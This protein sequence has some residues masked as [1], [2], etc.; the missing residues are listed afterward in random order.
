MTHDNH[1]F[2]NLADRPGHLIR[3]LHQIHVAMFLEECSDFNLTP[4]QFGVL[5]VLS[6]GT[7]R[8]QVTIARRIGVD[9]NTAAD[10]IKRLE[11]RGL[12]E[13]PGD[14]A[15][16]RTKLARITAAGEELVRNVQPGMMRA[17]SRLISPLGE[18]EYQQYMHLTRK[19][20][21]ANDHSSRAPW[22][23]LHGDISGNPQPVQNKK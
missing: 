4:I 6:G 18:D 9:R 11:K 1:Q 17:Q 19:L 23:P 21:E 10:V 13:R 20:L 2:E 22:K 16:K 7:A 15:D 8:D 5:T 14:P 12:L 3:R